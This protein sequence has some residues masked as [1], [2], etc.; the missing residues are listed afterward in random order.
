M[1]KL[2]Y[3]FYALAVFYVIS[4]ID[5]RLDA[6]TGSWRAQSIPTAL[7]LC[8]GWLCMKKHKKDNFKFAIEEGEEVI[9]VKV[10]MSA[11]CCVTEKYIYCSYIS[12]RDK[13]WFLKNAGK[14]AFF[15]TE[16]SI[17]I[18]RSEIARISKGKFK[19][20]E[21]MVIEMKNGSK[22]TPPIWGKDLAS[23]K[24]IMEFV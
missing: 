7:L 1:K 6:L 20:R 21:I 10:G 8:A 17:K 9:W 3:L 13:N 24:K 11:A 14:K 16:N 15:P 18:Q 5:F 12:D 4:P 23:L 22:I 19:L 2:A